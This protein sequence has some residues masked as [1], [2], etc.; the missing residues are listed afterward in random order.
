MGSISGPSSRGVVSNMLFWS[1]VTAYE[2]DEGIF[3]PLLPYEQSLLLG[4]L[5]MLRENPQNYLEDYEDID[6][7]DFNSKID[8]LM[9]RIIIDD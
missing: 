5:I 9:N 8:T 6:I 3:V 7:D 1:K 2:G 4:L